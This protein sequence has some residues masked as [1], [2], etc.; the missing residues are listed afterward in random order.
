MMRCARPIDRWPATRVEYTRRLGCCHR[1]IEPRPSRCSSSLTEAASPSGA[2]RT[3]LRSTAPISSH[4]SK[5]EPKRGSRCTVRGAHAPLHRD[6]LLALPP[7]EASGG[8][9]VPRAAKALWHSW[10]MSELWQRPLLLVVPLL[11][12]LV[13]LARLPRRGVGARGVA[14]FRC[15]FP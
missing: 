8:A 6:H 13:L 11:G 3:M 15:L 4:P 12:V 14:L 10:A 7:P 1:R 2:P 5:P 9:I